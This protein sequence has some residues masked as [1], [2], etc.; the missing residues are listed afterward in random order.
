MNL[1]T[2]RS[3]QFITEAIQDFAVAAKPGKILLD[4]G[5]GL[6]S[7][8]KKVILILSF[9]RTEECQSSVCLAIMGTC[10]QSY[11]CVSL[12]AGNEKQ[13]FRSICSGRRRD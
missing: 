5:W 13:F 8:A 10:S 11:C 9:C 12:T 3:T 2:L 1:Q 6:V 4:I 7:C